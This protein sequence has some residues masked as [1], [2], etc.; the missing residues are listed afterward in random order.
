MAVNLKRLF[1]YW[2]GIDTLG[3][4]CVCLV[5]YELDFLAYQSL[6]FWRMQAVA[7]PGIYRMLL[8][9]RRCSRSTIAQFLWAPSPHYILHNICRLHQIAPTSSTPDW[10]RDCDTLMLPDVSQLPIPPQ[11][12]FSKLPKSSSFGTAVI[13]TIFLSHDMLHSVQIFEIHFH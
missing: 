3:C 13:C 2:Q 9:C 10:N 5:C 4:C 11:F 1:F 8:P 12:Q 6:Y 7:V